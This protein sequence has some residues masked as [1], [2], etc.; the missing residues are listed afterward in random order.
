MPINFVTH[1]GISLTSACFAHGVFE[2]SRAGKCI[3][4]LLAARFERFIIDIF[5][6]SS[7][8][9][10]T[11]CP[12]SIN[13]GSR[14]VNASSIPFTSTA[15]TSQ[16]I[17][18]FSSGRTDAQSTIIP[19]TT[20]T[21]PSETL[22]T[23]GENRIRQITSSSLET[24][25]TVT[26]RTSESTTTTGSRISTSTI[27]SG[28]NLY[29][30]G[31]YQCSPS[32]NLQFL[33][34]V[35][36]DYI[37]NTSDSISVNFLYFQFNLHAAA[38]NDRP[39][40][41]ARSLTALEIP[42]QVELIGNVFKAASTLLPYQPSEL[43]SQRTNLNNSWY[44]VPT[45]RQPVSQYFLTTNL[46]R[47]DQGTPDG[48]PSEYFAEVRSFNRF[49]LGWGSID[50][51]MEDYDFAGDSDVI[52]PPNYISSSKEIRANSAGEIE[53]GCLYNAQQPTVAESNSSW[54]F[55]IINTTNSSLESFN[56]FG[57]LA[58]NLTSCGITPI[59]NVTLGNQTAD[60]NVLQY[61]R[62]MQST[63]W[64]WAPGEPRNVTLPD[65]NSIDDENM[66][67]RF[68]CALMD[69]SASA[70]ASRW[71]VEDCS[72]P[73]RAACRIA[74]QPYKWRLSE[75]SVAYSTAERACQT[76]SFFSTPRTGLENTYLYQNILTLPE[77][78]RSG[79][80]GDGSGVWLNFNSLD[81][82]GCW[83]T[84]GPNGTCPYSDDEDSLRQ[85]TVLIPVI[86]ALIVLLLAALTLFVKC[87]KN[88]R[89]SRKRI[90]GE[91]G[92]DYEGVP[93]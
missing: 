15:L 19:E 27:S 75:D 34:S 57:S 68:R 5:W 92:W 12:V 21:S 79:L 45:S 89:N 73:H 7:L 71:R 3:S 24:A 42:T 16:N 53:S 51:E 82:E 65:A 67:D 59:L 72:I 80:S 11:L 81:T 8:R 28:N 40:D 56:R 23:D 61:V 90:R 49:L 48:W 33:A 74:N 70:N 29:S 30:F 88:R 31:P 78:S 46:P 17:S 76:N 62:F 35:L 47:C 41:P 32:L 60:M 64:N 22:S 84:T 14:P 20:S 36:V 38:S 91:G 43:S 77:D 54:A 37:R 13:L 6:D 2:D 44:H 55:T 63:I 1:A 83:V 93:S 58:S 66:Q 87:N 25:S 4:N 18:D 10:F 69:T 50:P 85:Q 86:A 39:N 52:F 26:S 9:Q